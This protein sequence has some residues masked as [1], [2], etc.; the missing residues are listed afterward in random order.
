MEEG[1]GETLGSPWP[2]HSRPA[3]RGPS[4]ALI[5][6]GDIWKKTR[7]DEESEPYLSFLVQMVQKWRPVEVKG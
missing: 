3:P 7:K 6:L 5:R 4:T 2:G 1:P